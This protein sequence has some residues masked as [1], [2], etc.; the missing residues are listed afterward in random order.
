M[1]Q[2]LGFNV[3]RLGAESIKSAQAFEELEL[4]DSLKETP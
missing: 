3:V 4:I 2:S 1:L